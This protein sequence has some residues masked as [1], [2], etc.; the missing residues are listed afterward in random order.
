[1]GECWWKEWE[2]YLFV[3]VDGDIRLYLRF[4]VRGMIWDSGEEVDKEYDVIIGVSIWIL[5]SCGVK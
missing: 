5:S 1:M 2:Y 4:I 3:G